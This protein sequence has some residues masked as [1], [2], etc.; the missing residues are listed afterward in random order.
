[1]NEDMKRLCEAAEDALVQCIAIDLHY[2][3][4][5]RNVV[6]ATLRELKAVT[7]Q[8]QDTSIHEAQVARYTGTAINRILQES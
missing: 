4:T 2:T 6:L 1:M 8:P 7:A 3:E 5:A